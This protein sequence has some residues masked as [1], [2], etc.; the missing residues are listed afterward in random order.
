[1]NIVKPPVR[2]ETISSEKSEKEPILNQ[3]LARE[4]GKNIMMA[5]LKKLWL[6][7]GKYSIIL[8]VKGWRLSLKLE[9]LRD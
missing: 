2:I 1:M 8:V 6:K 5:M 9:W 3:T 7:S 4:E